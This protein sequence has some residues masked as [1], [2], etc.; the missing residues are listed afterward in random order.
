[1]T[2]CCRDKTYT[3]AKVAVH[4]AGRECTYS[5]TLTLYTL[6]IISSAMKTLSKCSSSRRR[7]SNLRSGDDY[8]T[9]DLL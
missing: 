3:A 6:I 7:K 1:M 8:N 2:Q 9:M 5:S 4:G